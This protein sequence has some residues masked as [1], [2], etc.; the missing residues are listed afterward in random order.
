[1]LPDGTGPVVEAQEVTPAV[2]EI[3]Q[4]KIPVGAVALVEPMTNVV[5]VSEPPSVALPVAPKNIVGF[6]LATT[7]ELEEVVVVTAA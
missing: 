1:L 3:L 7:V 2:P 6:D 4:V 5:K